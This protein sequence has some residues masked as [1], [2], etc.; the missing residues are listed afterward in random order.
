[1]TQAFLCAAS[2]LP[3]NDPR[4][5]HAA[6]CPGYRCGHPFVPCTARRVTTVHT[7]GA[8]HAHHPSAPTP[9]HPL[10]FIAMRLLLGIQTP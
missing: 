1:M 3:T 2:S 9:C 8:Q 6:V 4:A 10:V 7:L 5:R